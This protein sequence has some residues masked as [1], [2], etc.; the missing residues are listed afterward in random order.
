MSWST[1]WHLVPKPR[2][3]AAAK[4][5]QPY[6]AFL[7]ADFEATCQQGK[8]FDYANEII[9]FPVFLM[10]WKDKNGGKASQLEVAAE[11]HSFVRPSWQ[12][13]LSKF[14]MDLTGITQGEVDVAPEFST[15]LRSLRAFLVEQGVIEKTGKHRLKFCWCTDGPWDIAHFIV[16]QCFISQVPV[17]EWLAGD[18]LDVR[19]LV[20]LHTASRSD[21][22]AGTLNIPTQ[23]T[24]LGLA[25][26]LGRQHRGVDDARNLGRILQQLAV[27]HVQ[28]Q[29]NTKVNLRRRWPW[30][31]K[32]GQ[33]LEDRL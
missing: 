16:K 15:V 21:R 17:P 23:L 24:A 2:V 5:K 6:D 7:V 13:K 8:N 3:W 31:G 22:P 20:R 12:P 32:A 9:E 28:L 1:L 26:F 18:V 11:F 4:V 14:C 30:M 25:P 27:E 29:P 10:R 19:Q 33:I